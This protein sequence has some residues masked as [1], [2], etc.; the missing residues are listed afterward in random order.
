M[1]TAW[2]VGIALFGS[3][4]AFAGDELDLVN[5]HKNYGFQGVAMILGSYEKSDQSAG[6]IQKSLSAGGLG[7]LKMPLTV[8][9]RLAPEVVRHGDV[10]RCSWQWGVFCH[11]DVE[12]KTRPP[13]VWTAQCLKGNR[14]VKGVELK[15]RK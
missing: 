1:R 5:Q 8:G 12:W 7:D 11:A 9:K 6:E 2:W 3:S 13:A 4:M 15:T 10:G 14:R